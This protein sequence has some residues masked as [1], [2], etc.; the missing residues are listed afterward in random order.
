MQVGSSA[1]S[2]AP[3]SVCRCEAGR[4]QSSTVRKNVWVCRISQAAPPS[5]HRAKKRAARPKAWEVY[6]TA[7][8]TLRLTGASWLCEAHLKLLSCEHAASPC[9]PCLLGGDVGCTEQQKNSDSSERVLKQTKENLAQGAL[10]IFFLTF[11]YFKIKNDGQEMLYVM[12]YL[13]DDHFS[14]N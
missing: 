8:W 4:E 11:M 12:S 2:G 10:F 5:H 7:V 9:T 1:S 13:S 14:T 6:T 3:R